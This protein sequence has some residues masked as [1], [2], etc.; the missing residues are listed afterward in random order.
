MVE[1][2]DEDRDPRVPRAHILS[3]CVY[4]APS[5]VSAV[6][7]IAALCRGVKTRCAVATSKN[8]L[9]KA[10]QVRLE[11][12]Q[13]AKEE[14]ELLLT[15][16]IEKEEARTRAAT[17]LQSL[18]RGRSTRKEIKPRRASA[19]TIAKVVEFFGCNKETSTGVNVVNR[20]AATAAAADDDLSFLVGTKV[21]ARY[22]GRYQWFNAVISATATSVNTDSDETSTVTMDLLFAD[23]DAEYRVP[24]YRVRLPGQTEP[25]Q[26]EAGALVDGRYDPKSSKLYP[27][28][29]VNA[30]PD[31]QH[32]M[33]EFD[34]GD[35]LSKVLAHEL[36][37]MRGNATVEY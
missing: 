28:V 8:E 16:A 20:T 30:W 10:R 29:V 35:K 15:A 12:Q 22:R 32:F 11:A 36:N 9:E 5:E 21:E 37:L 14:A 3:Q 19:R 4:P 34:D 13:E 25:P 27:G 24:R 26:L 2:D 17:A 23:G 6:T 33:I 18:A 1:F 31:G 7:R